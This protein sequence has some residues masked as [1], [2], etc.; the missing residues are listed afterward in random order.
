MTRRIERA[1]PLLRRG[2]PVTDG[3]GEPADPA[4]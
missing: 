3:Y 1:K 4:S 2:A